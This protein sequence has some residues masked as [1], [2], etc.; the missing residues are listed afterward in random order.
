MEDIRRRLPKC[1]EPMSLPPAKG[2]D[3]GI[4]LARN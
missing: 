1:V 3:R 4:R 2:L